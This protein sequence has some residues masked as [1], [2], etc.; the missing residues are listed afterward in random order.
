VQQIAEKFKLALQCDNESAV[1]ERIDMKYNR[2]LYAVDYHGAG[3]PG[4]MGCLQRR[5]N[6]KSNQVSKN[7]YRRRP[8]RD[9]GL[10]VPT[11]V[12]LISSPRFRFHRGR[13][14]AHGPSRTQ[15]FVTSGPNA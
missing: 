5:R 12:F 13:I 6:R 7:E 1:R 11:I 9:R 2:L 3:V 8:G 4:R 15:K 10:R 14:L